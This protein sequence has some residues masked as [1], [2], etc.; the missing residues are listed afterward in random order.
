MDKDGENETILDKFGCHMGLY[1]DEDNNVVLWGEVG[2]GTDGMM[3]F[4]ITEARK[5]AAQILWMTGEIK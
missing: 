4:P 5:L 1:L 2:L 3:Q